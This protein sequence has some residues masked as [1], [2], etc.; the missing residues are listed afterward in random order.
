MA[1]KNPSPRTRFKKG[2]TGNPGGKTA[3][4]VA[5]ERRNADAAMRIRERLLA[6]AEAKLSGATDDAALEFIEAAMLKL[7][8]DAEDRGLG[9]PVQ[10]LRSSDGTMS[11][12]PTIDTSKL[13]SSTM[14]EILSATDPG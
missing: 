3:E 8:K 6:A 10:D 12:K 13:S 7:L 11:P 4:Q 1:N 2:Q 14:A 5:I 9:A